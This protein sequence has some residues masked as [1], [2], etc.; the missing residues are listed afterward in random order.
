MSTSPGWLAWPSTFS[1]FLHG[2]NLGLFMRQKRSW[3]RHSCRKSVTIYHESL[4]IKSH[5]W[6]CADCRHL[7]MFQH[8]FSWFPCSSSFSVFFPLVERME[9]LRSLRKWARRHGNHFEFQWNSL[10]RILSPKWLH[11]FRPIQISTK[12]IKLHLPPL[13]GWESSQTCHCLH[14]SY[15]DR[16]QPNGGEGMGY[17]VPSIFT[18][19]RYSIYIVCI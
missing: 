3:S 19:H 13:L 12:S 9:L 7:H 14:S 8:Q 10:S 6:M 1:E 17:I 16:H 4:L 15:G 18:Y 5:L 2:T 11:I